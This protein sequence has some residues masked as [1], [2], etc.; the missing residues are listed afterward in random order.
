MSS[1]PEAPLSESIVRLTPTPEGFELHFPPLRNRGAAV[2][3]GVFG[4]L[5]VALPVAA[6]AG[7]G[8][9]EG[10]GAFGWLAIVLVGGFA[11]P[12][13]AFGVVFLALAA[14][15]LANSLTVTVGANRIATVRRLFGVTLYHRTLRYAEVAA[16][17]PLSAARLQ[18]RFSAEPRFQLV[19]RSR[20]PGQRDLVIAESLPGRAAMERLAT[21]L[22]SA[23]GVGLE[24]N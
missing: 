2:G 23:I 11:L 10:P 3:F 14:Y 8:I 20:T 21:R 17:V 6:A 16:V 1:I 24:E 19:A 5:S 13:L 22:A 9:I 12:L 4:A 15:L 18:N 7:L